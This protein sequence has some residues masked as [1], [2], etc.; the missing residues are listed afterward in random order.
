MSTTR[1][2]FTYRSVNC[3]VALSLTLSVVG[4]L[5]TGCSSEGDGTGGSG[6]GGSGA[7]GLPTATCKERCDKKLQACGATPAQATSQC[8]PV[9]EDR[10]TETQM[11]CLEDSPCTTG[12]N[13][14]K[15]ECGITKPTTTSGPTSG[16]TTSTGMPIEC[17]D[18]MGQPAAG[19]DR[20][21][22]QCN[23]G[24]EVKGCAQSSSDACDVLCDTYCKPSSS[25]VRE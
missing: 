24:L 4:A 20:Y 5:A 7:A 6:D 2:R 21:V 23:A 17:L 14:A 13:E 11:K 18:G 10:L 3:F 16:P 1:T 8:I 22:C 15:K 19:F 25:C 12:I 9:C